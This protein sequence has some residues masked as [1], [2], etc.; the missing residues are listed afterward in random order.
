MKI[1]NFGSINIDHTYSLPHFVQAGETISSTN[2]EKNIGGKGLNQSISMAKAGLEVYHAGVISNQEKDFVFNEINKYNIKTDYIKYS[3][4]P[5][6]HAVIQVEESG[7]NCIILYSGTNGEV[8]KEYIDEVF[9]NFEKGDFCVLQ[10]EISNLDYIFK[11]CSEKEMKIIFNPSP[12]TEKLKELFKYHIEYILVNEVEAMQIS[13]FKE[14]EK[15]L[16][17]FKNTYP[18]MK[19][20]LTLGKDGVI[21]QDKEN[22]IHHP[23]F[24]IPVVD[25]T[26]AGDTFTGYFIY[27][28]CNNMDIKDIL[29]LCSAASAIAVSR[30]GATCSIPLKH[31]VDEFLEK[32]K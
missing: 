5:N 27:G 10:N 30:K 23:I 32:I 29:R 26:A 2:F 1:L 7:Q 19:V 28:I 31:E 16:E 9:N 15:S 14:P 22:K 17:F 13:G 11:K 21:Y 12:W 4:N 3:N 18:N 8:T 25:T 6:G 24:D 20:V